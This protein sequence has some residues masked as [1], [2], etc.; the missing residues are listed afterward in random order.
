MFHEYFCK[1]TRVSNSLQTTSNP[2]AEL[3]NQNW[4]YTFDTHIK[5]ALG[6]S[7]SKD[8]L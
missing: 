7:P 5:C 2:R 8:V 4:Y 3:F 1:V 6:H